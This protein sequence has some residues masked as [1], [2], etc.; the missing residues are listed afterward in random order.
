MSQG[1]SSGGAGPVTS[2]LSLQ[3]Q[4]CGTICAHLSK[5]PTMGLSY[6]SYWQRSRDSKVKSVLVKE[7]TSEGSLPSTSNRLQNRST[8]PSWGPGLCNRQS[9]KMARQPPS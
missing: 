9:P 5:P 6:S 3:S 4:A 7:L 8:T 1:E 2:V